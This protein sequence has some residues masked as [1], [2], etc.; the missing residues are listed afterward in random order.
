[1]SG[2]YLVEFPQA[3]PPAPPRKVTLTDVFPLPW[4]A[5]EQHE[6]KCEIIA[7]NGKRI[8]TLS[9]NAFGFNGEIAE[10]VL[11]AINAMAPKIEKK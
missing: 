10:R 5:G 6:S 4:V 8:L 11:Q 2:I 7:A 9:G 3:K 1:M